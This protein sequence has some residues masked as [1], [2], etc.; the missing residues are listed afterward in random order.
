MLPGD[1][2]ISEC[3]QEDAAMV[4]I[5]IIIGLLVWSAVF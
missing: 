5:K 3:P 1:A 4:I 2:A